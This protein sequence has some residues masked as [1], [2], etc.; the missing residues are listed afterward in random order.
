[1]HTVKSYLK[2][3]LK[4]KNQ[5]GVHSPFVY[6]LV[7]KCFYDSKYYSDYKHLKNYR[8]FL[9]Q[10]QS[11]L[12]ITDYGSGSKSFNSASRSVSN[13]T[14]TSGTQLKHAKLLFRLAHYF[15]PK[16]ILELGTSVGIGSISLALGAKNSKVTSIEGCTETANFTKLLF[17]QFN[18][19]N[20]IIKNNTFENAIRH[21]KKESFDFVFFDG[22]HDEIATLKYFE[23]L[24]PHIHNDSM[25]IFD[26]IY[27]SEGM[28]KAWNQIKKHQKVTVSIDT[29]QYGIVFFRK[30]QAKEHFVIRL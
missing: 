12:D 22:H 19:N 1:M 26:D 28:T 23:Q 7:T 16:Q 21:L 15:Q 9:L 13:I 3:L 2:F 17:K 25:F 6:D 11:V 24:L 10:N 20:V 29:F 18:I 27:W 4:S 14:K 30:E 5:H 8:N